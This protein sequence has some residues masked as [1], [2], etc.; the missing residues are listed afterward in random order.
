MIH[1]SFALALFLLI[2]FRTDAF[3]EY[4]ELLKLGKLFK[5]PGYKQT[6]TDGAVL[7]Y[8]E[9][10]AEF[11]NNF[12]T[13]LISCPICLSVWVGF[14]LSLFVGLE[15]VATIIILGLIIYL[16]ADKLV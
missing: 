3:A 10:L 15:T 13:R 9:F 11:H 2:W 5:L 1:A 6:K 4:C 16:A 14:F 8:P 7:S 12:F